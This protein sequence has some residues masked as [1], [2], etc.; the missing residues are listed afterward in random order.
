[1]ADNP[2]IS[3]AERYAPELPLLARFFLLVEQNI[4]A[5]QDLGGDE[6]CRAFREQRNAFLQQLRHGA[7]MLSL[8]RTLRRQIKVLEVNERELQKIRAQEQE[9]EQK[10][11]PPKTNISPSPPS[12]LVFF[13]GG[14]AQYPEGFTGIEVRIKLCLLLVPNP[15]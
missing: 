10:Q 11:I 7:L 6:F 2:C 13:S 3:V 1:M 12:M 14:R 8:R 9:P 15:C 5:F 4:R